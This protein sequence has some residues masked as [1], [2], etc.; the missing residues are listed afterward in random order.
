MPPR[1]KSKL[2]IDKLFSGK[3]SHNVTVYPVRAVYMPQD[4]EGITPL[5]SVSKR[6][7]KHAVD[8]NRIKRQMREAFRLN[9]TLL[10]DNPHIV[11][12]FI[13]L[14]DSHAPSS[15]IHRSICKALEKIC[16][17]TQPATT[18]CTE[19]VCQQNGIADEKTEPPADK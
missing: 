1:L 8:R 12:A 14:S 11:I 9:K 10:G 17:A 18:D 19:E 7:F 13:W 4:S 16:K 3:V 2:V 15:R 5:F 6:H